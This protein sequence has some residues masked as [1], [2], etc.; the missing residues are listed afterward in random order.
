MK[1]EELNVDSLVFRGMKAMLSAEIIDTIKTM[2]EKRI[3]NG[4]VS[5]K[6]KLEMLE[7]TD[8]NGEFH[9]TLIIDPEV[10]SRI[11]RK[12]KSKCGDTG[13]RMGYGEDGE[14]TILTN[15][16]SMDEIPKDQKGA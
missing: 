16:I 1:Q 14:L 11:E 13:G 5:L 10:G 12:Y 2:E 15:Q 6:I 8:E 9:R 3:H 4:S 7:R